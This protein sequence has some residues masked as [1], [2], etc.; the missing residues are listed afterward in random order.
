MADSK[1]VRIF[2]ASN[3]YYDTLMKHQGHIFLLILLAISLATARVNAYNAE[4]E[5]WLQRLD[6]VVQQ[7]EHINEQK[8][9]RLQQMQTMQ[10][11]MSDV[12]ELY[13][14]NRTIY[15]ECFTF[16]SELAMS[17]VDANLQIASQRRDAH[18]MAEWQIQ[19]SFILAST[20]QLLEATNALEGLKPSLLDRHLRLDYYAQQEYL[21]S[22]LAQYSWSEP[23]KEAYQ[24]QAWTYTD[25]IYQIMEPTDDNYLWWQS[26]R[27][28]S[29]GNGHEAIL[30]LRPVVDTL[31]LTTRHDA[32]LAY[33]LA[34]MYQEQ[35]DEDLYLQYMARSGIA[36]LRAANQDIA[37]LEELS[38]VLYDISQRD[39]RRGHGLFES[40]DQSAVDLSR[41]Y[42]YI[43]VCLETSRIYNNLVRT[44]SIARVMDD[45]LASYRERVAEQQRRQ[46]AITW[47]LAIL[48]VILLVAVIIGWRQR[49]KLTQSRSQLESANVQLSHHRAALT[50]ANAELVEANRKLQAAMEQQAEV[51]RELQESNYVKEEYVGYVFS[52]CSNY[53]SKMDEY[54]KNINR[55]TKV[56]LYDEVLQMTEKTNLVQD[57][58]K[59]FYQNFDAIFLHIY[60]DFITDFNNLLQPEERIEPRKGELLNTDLR[61]YALVRLGITDSVKI[62]EFLH[63]SPQTVYNNRLKTRNKAIVPKEHFADYV[64]QLGRF[65]NS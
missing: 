62:A 53:I 17:L 55:K 58:L 2:A 9:H 48:F 15:D 6:S 43:N 54:R 57:E 46:Q 44:V 65:S 18:G 64:R 32:M 7:R 24:Q 8:R 38:S 52:L 36:D 56:K 39:S 12:E 23:M 50:H 3:E 49:R 14:L 29:V 59:E 28:Y 42:T 51:N 5:R 10:R 34:R 21:Y 1:I 60:P 22:H 63:V 35:G 41:A 26:W 47:I 19:R 20:G 13:Q 37:S 61:I 33:C 4:S 11:G 45:I 30:A 27:A 25:S 16:D 40:K 31:S